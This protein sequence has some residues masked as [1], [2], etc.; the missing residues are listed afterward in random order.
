MHHRIITSSP[1]LATDRHSCA[2]GNETN[3]RGL[4]AVREARLDR[5]EGGSTLKSSFFVHIPYAAPQG[6]D[7]EALGRAL[8]VVIRRLVAESLV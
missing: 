8:G 1:P 2:L 5:T 3:W 6:N 7:H 4:A